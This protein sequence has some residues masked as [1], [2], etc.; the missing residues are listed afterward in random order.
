MRLGTYHTVTGQHAGAWR[1][2]TQATDSESLAQHVAAARAAQDAGLDFLLVTDVLGEQADPQRPHE[3]RADLVPRL[4]PTALLAALAATTRDIGLVGSF[5]TT[6]EDPYHLARRLASLDHLSE[7]RA[8]WNVVTSFQALASAAAGGEPLPPHADRYARAREAL[9]VACALWDAWE[10]DAVVRD[11]RAGRYVDPARV[12]RV[13]H[14]GPSFDVRTVLPSSRSP[15]GRPVLF[16]AGASEAGRALAADHADVV[17]TSQ[18]HL[19]DA[20]EFYREVKHRVADA[21]RDP[22]GVLVM[23]GVVAIVAPT[24]AQAREVRARLDEAID[25]E[26]ARRRLSALLGW[27]TS[28]LP[29]DALLDAAPAQTEGHRSRARQL[30][31]RAVRERLTVR[32]LARV[33][34]ATRGHLLVV[35]SPQDVADELLAWFE[36]DAA[37][38]FVVGPAVMPAGLRRFTRDVVPL[39]RAA[40]VRPDRPHGGTLRDRLGVGAPTGAARET[41]ALNR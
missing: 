6:F 14:A 19:P 33:A 21:G 18:D 40:G 11:R 30:H 37:D 16:Q 41:T 24:R 12:R 26:R 20:R 25:D 7:G 1:V 5:S 27:D 38:G 34:E 13:E 28:A 15:Q 22:D 10:R 35:G 36:A 2:S 32:E 39:L 3:V 31:E 4:E 17:F 29:A 9:E 8:G 23:P